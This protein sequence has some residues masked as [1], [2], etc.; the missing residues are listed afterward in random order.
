MSTED[1]RLHALN[2]CS[3]E[4]FLAAMDI[5]WE[6]APWVGQYAVRNRPYPSMDA[7]HAEM[8]AAIQALPQKELLAFFAGHPELGGELARCGAMTAASV[9]EQGLWGLERLEHQ[10]A[11]EWDHY[12]LLY[13]E[14][15][16]FPF[17]LCI[18]QHNLASA[19][20]AFQ[21]RLRNDQATEIHNALQEIAAISRL[22][23]HD[24]ALVTSAPTN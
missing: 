5:V 22:R 2:T 15:F 23:L 18:R 7:L 24:A 9:R 12:N 1:L 13:R 11:Q 20:Q 16:G 21:T 4:Q 8:L 10:H 3:T 6:N 17:I 19:L 14:R